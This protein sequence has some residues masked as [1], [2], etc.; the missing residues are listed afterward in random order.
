MRVRWSFLSFVVLVL[1]T[2][3]CQATTMSELQ[4]KGR[5]F[6]KAS[7]TPTDTVSLRQQTTI[8][9]EVG[10]DTWFTKGTRVHRFEVE[11]ALDCQSKSVCD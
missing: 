3:S 6:I 9:I 2:W 8:T 11:N 4:Q 10:T 5:V 7:V 1:I